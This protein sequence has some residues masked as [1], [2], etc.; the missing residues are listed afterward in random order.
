MK[1]FPNEYQLLLL[2]SSYFN[3]KE[4]FLNFK[5]SHPIDWVVFL[6]LLKRNRVLPMVCH[7]LHRWNVELPIKV[8]LKAARFEHIKNA[9]Q[10]TAILLEI[11]KLFTDN[12]IECIHFK[13]ASL[14][15][16][17]YR[18]PTLRQYKDIDILIE[19]KNIK[20]A[21]ELLI[22][23][24]F[25]TTTPLFKKQPYLN[26]EYEHFRKDYFFTRAGFQIELHWSLI[27]LLD[28]DVNMDFFSNTQS[29]PLQ[30]QSI[31]ILD[32]PYYLSYLIL[33][34]CISG[35]SRLHW[36]IDVVDFI[37]T[38]PVCWQKTKNILQSAGYVEMFNE[39]TELTALFFDLEKQIIS[40]CP[41]K[42]IKNSISLMQLPINNNQLSQYNLLLRYRQGILLQF[43]LR[44]KLRYFKKIFATSPEDWHLLPLPKCLFFLYYPLRPFLWLIRN[45]R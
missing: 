42:L 15:Q 41:Q 40:K 14:S 7:N 3:D 12:G 18:D 5:D 21:H 24:G 25:S 44:K 27:N 1:K 6:S 22:S 39:T 36:L 43:S 28:S 35:W 30:N 2:C 38:Q 11:N 23:N 45:A 9:L 34:G 31:Q 33:H 29:I 20:F 37:K 17:L 26:N 13:G 32:N 8:E 10:Q 19:R 4:K 16:Y